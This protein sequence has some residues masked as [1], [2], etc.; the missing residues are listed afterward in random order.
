MV[1]N[2]EYCPAAVVFVAFISIESSNI[3]RTAPEL[4][5]L[6]FTTVDVISAICNAFHNR[7]IPIDH[8]QHLGMSD[9]E[10]L[11]ERVIKEYDTY[12]IKTSSVG[13]HL[14]FQYDK[15]ITNTNH[16]QL[17]TDVKSESKNRGA[18]PGLIVMTGSRT[19]SKKHRTAQ[20]MKILRKYK[21]IHNT[22]VKPLPAPLKRWLLYNVYR[23]SRPSARSTNHKLNKVS[24]Q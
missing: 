17:N 10:S 9:Q 5:L 22:T 2:S 23:D 18:C 11:A 6:I 12:T 15:E 3:R 13:L 14:L 20:G 21:T 1:G 4:V 24:I 7:L 16:A 19:P 8:L